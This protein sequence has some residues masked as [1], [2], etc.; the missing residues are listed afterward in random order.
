MQFGQIDR[1]A[2]H[3]NDGSVL[4][5][6]RFVDLSQMSGC[7]V[8]PHDLLVQ[9]QAFTVVDPLDGFEKSLSVRLNNKVDIW[10]GTAC[11]FLMLL[12]RE[13]EMATRCAI[14]GLR[15]WP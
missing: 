7:P 4:V 5:Q 3:G 8:R 1:T 2:H 11:Q 14:W 9:G 15:G 10:F 12:R 6:D 13:A